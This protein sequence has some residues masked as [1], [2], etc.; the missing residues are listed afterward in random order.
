G[1]MDEVAKALGIDAMEL[2]RRNFIRTGD[3]NATGQTI[4]SAVWSDDC[5]TRALDALGTRT[6]DEG[7]VRIGR[8]VACY[9]QSYGRISW[10]HDT[11][12]AWVGAELDG[13]VVVRSAVP[14][15]GA[16]QVSALC[17]I[18]A[19]VLGV[20]MD[21]V[22]AYA[23]DTAVNP[24]AGT[25]TASRQ[26]FMSGNAVRLAASKVRARL[27]ERA[28]RHFEVE[29]DRVDLADSHAFVAG[30]PE[31]T[32]PLK[33]LAAVCAAEGV[34]RSELAIYRA[35]FS[36]RPDEVD[37]G[38]RVFPDFTYGAQAIEVAVDTETGEV[39]VLKSVGAH[40][41]GQAINPAAVA[42]QIEGGSVMGHGYALSE[43]IVYTEGGIA[44]PSLS[45]YLIPTPEDVAEVAA[46]ILESHS[47]L[48]PFGA[49]G[50]GEPSFAP[51]APAVANAV[52]DA[53]G[54]RIFDLPITPE[55][56]VK[57]LQD[58]GERPRGAGR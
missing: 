21:R 56:V 4:E 25:S 49:K 2:R 14:D 57:A 29:P 54:V 47:G 53:L 46:I 1:Q 24:L 41:I 8:G 42:G 31:R 51:V 33:E 9:Q 3:K 55:R 28:A 26:L 20:P 45:E 44:T 11:S 30:E 5:M 19:E 48:G 18:A 32:L 17:Q 34:H 38:G 10:F 22:T 40:D 37:L 7:A 52:A 58:A 12:E 16:G 50:I 35:P 15:I 6:P 43:E 23:G 36:D 39:S 13:T 27:V